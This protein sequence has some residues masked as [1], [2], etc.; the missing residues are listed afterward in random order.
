MRNICHLS[1]WQDLTLYLEQEQKPTQPQ[2]LLFRQSGILPEFHHAQEG[3]CHKNVSNIFD[4]QCMTIFIETEILVRHYSLSCWK[5]TA[6]QRITA[7]CKLKTNLPYI[8]GPF[9][10]SKQKAKR[11]LNKIL[12]LIIVY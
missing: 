6:R 2:M 9:S 11:N 5:T 10:K 1:P 8:A 7:V 12:N 3:L 4:K